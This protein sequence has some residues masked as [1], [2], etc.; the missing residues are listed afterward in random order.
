MQSFQ[1]KQNKNDSKG[2]DNVLDAI[3]KLNE[4]I[5]CLAINS[6]KNFN[7]SARNKHESKIKNKQIQN[8]E[9]KLKEMKLREEKMKMSSKIKCQLKIEMV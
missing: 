8:L 7:N 9:L 4:S 6:N 2:S 5:G 1:K 3:N